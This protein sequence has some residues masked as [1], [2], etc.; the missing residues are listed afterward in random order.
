MTERLEILTA[1]MSTLQERKIEYLVKQ[2]KASVVGAKF[3]LDTDKGICTVD[4]HGRVVWK[5]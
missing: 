4:R 1:P 2:N 3:I 5:S